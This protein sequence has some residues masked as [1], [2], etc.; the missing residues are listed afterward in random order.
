[1]RQ[2]MTGSTVVD[3]PPGQYTVRDNDGMRN[4][5]IAGFRQATGDG[6]YQLIVG[7]GK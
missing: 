3:V 6:E 7:P 1:M 4:V 5:D 2:Q